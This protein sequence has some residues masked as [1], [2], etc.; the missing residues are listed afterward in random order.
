MNEFGTCPD[1]AHL[2]QI[3]EL[4]LSILIKDNSNI[5]IS[6]KSRDVAKAL[7]ERQLR[8]HNE[9]CN[10]KSNPEPS[11]HTKPNYLRPPSIRKS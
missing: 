8:N 6:Y 1:A 7:R 4:F 2:A 9:R 5:K 3:I 10:Q 11:K